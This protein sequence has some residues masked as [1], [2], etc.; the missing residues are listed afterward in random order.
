M[1]HFSKPLRLLLISQLFAWSAPLMAQH[2]MHGAGPTPAATPT[3]PLAK[4]NLVT[5]AATAPDG[6]L[7][8]VNMNA[9][10]QLRIL[11]SRDGGQQW[12]AERVLDTAQ[13]KPAPAGES[14]VQLAFGPRQQVVIAYPQSLGKRFTGEVRLIRSSD[15]GANFS[16]PVTV[17]ADRQII[18]H[19]F[20]RV[21][22]DGDGVLHSIW[23]D[24]REKAALTKAGV[25]DADL[26]QQYRGS[27]VYRNVSLDG[28][29]SFGPDLK[30]ADHSCECC[31]IATT[32]DDSGKIRLMWR[33]VFAPNL[34]DHA[35]ATLTAETPLISEPVR[36][37]FDNW[38][39]DACPHHGGAL[40]K[41]ADGS[42]HAL[43][44]GIRGEVAAVRYGRLTAG[45]QPQGESRVLPDERA[46]HA[47]IAVR[48]KKVVILYRVF[49]GEQTLVKAW[50]SD[51]DGQH[52][53]LRQLAS[54]A[55]ENDYPRFVSTLP[56]QK[57]Q[58][59]RWIWNTKGK[60]YVETL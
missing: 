28:G 46:E 38:A 33:H 16:A 43:W 20:P 37:T 40:A 22:F 42:F 25:A 35:F 51:D 15:G 41:A 6:S 55:E 36:A 49:D 47:D 56:Q 21:L 8:V 45:G 60:L 18:G 39:V 53:T 5:T 34:R 11:Q 19:S 13:D 57:N 59:L 54:S 24:G 23:L 52:F 30:L 26:K 10:G 3:V 44:F 50:I 31:R 2:T 29:A 32:L 1:P 27:A 4:Q 58:P 48:G 9:Q 7:W 17:H 14:P 12:L